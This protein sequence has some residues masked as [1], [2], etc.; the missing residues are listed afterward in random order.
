MAYEPV[1]GLEVHSQL[2][3]QSKIFCG[4]SAEFGA[5]PNTHGCPVCLGL[6]GALPVLN[7]HAVELAMRLALSL[8][9]TI[10]PRSRFLRKNY[11][12]PDL[13]K[14]Y[15]I[16]Q[17]QSNEEMPL[18]TGGGIDVPT[19]KGQKHI[20]L[21]RIHMEEDAG[22]SIHDE[23]FVA[24]GES[25]VDVNRCGVPLIEIVSEPD[26]GSSEE[27]AHFLTRLRQILVYTGVSEGDME[28]GHVRIDAN[29]S[30]RP[31]GAAEL[32]VKVEI[33]NMNS[34]RNCQRALDAEIRRQVG[35]LETGGTVVQE[36]MTYDPDRD[37]VRP[38]RSKEY[39]DDYRYFP[40]PDL[41]PI[42]VNDAWIEQAHTE[43]P[44]LPEVRRARLEAE[45]DLNA[46]LVEVLTATR[47][48]AD[49]FE[50]TV[51]SGAPPARAANWIQGDVMRTLNERKIPISGL[52]IPPEALA[53]LIGMVDKGTI[54]T[55]I[56]RTVFA[57]MAESGDAPEVIV[58]RE[59]LVQIS[60]EGALEDLVEMVVAEH[61]SEADRYRGGDRKLLGFFMGKVMK[62]SKG[63]ANPQLANEL[64]R[65][66]LG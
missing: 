23:A 20:R 41:V 40:E 29:A 8:G 28:K 4:C 10:Q 6:P 5:D 48:V 49:Y 32:G 34:I 24:A 57:E 31:V 2:A 54:S 26:I 64:I 63:V 1:I 45:Y 30:I 59:G 65:K 7:R 50:S 35:I 51:S 14:G 46:E 37:T 47:E 18:A 15:Q 3:T 36:T 22:K 60:D 27:A 43:V 33:K 11:F 9:C 38:M 66:K 12:Y 17:F 21:V 52:K 13:P 19:E 58:E 42:L 61:P 53:T 44:E 39:S 56:G 55:S 25:L 62:A 16:S